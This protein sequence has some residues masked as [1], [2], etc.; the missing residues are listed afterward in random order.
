MQKENSNNRFTFLRLLGVSLLTTMILISNSCDQ[1]D[2]YFNENTDN[3]II[4]EPNGEDSNT[5]YSELFSK[6]FNPNMSIDFTIPAKN[7]EPKDVLAIGWEETFYIGVIDFG[8][9][10]FAFE[11]K[12]G[13]INDWGDYMGGFALG[14]R[15]QDYYN[16]NPTNFFDLSGVDHISFKIKSD[17]VKASELLFMLQAGGDIEGSTIDNYMTNGT[18]MAAGWVDV[19]IDLTLA[20][21]SNAPLDKT[22]T[23]FAMKGINT[24]LKNET[25]HFKDIKYLDSSNNIVNIL[26][27]GGWNRNALAENPTIEATNPIPPSTTYY[28]IFSDASTLSSGNSVNNVSMY[29][30]WWW[31]AARYSQE[32]V[33]GNMVSKTGFSGTP[34]ESYAITF[35]TTNVS[36]T[37][38]KIISIDVYPTSSIE[39]F[40]F[41]VMDANE[42]MKD[43]TFDTTSSL[44]PNMWNTVV[45]DISSGIDTTS[46]NSIGL[47]I[48]SGIQGGAIFIDNIFIY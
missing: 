24:I 32:Y 9:E 21:F 22:A 4:D 31:G 17:S 2:K 33:L 25:I 8:S 3:P 14:M 46:L 12:A 34:Q 45:L 13:N 7:I 44:T 20:P 47:V 5:D 43:F 10:G 23:I 39:S 15:P 18:N 37:T 29:G 30:T 48:H 28:K 16:W 38:N 35:A 41:R 40:T 36:S 42:T 26:P 19:T 27:T 1:L 6:I 11:A